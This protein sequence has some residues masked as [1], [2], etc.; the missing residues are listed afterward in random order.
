MTDFLAISL[1]PFWISIY[2]V[3]PTSIFLLWLDRVLT[4]FYLHLDHK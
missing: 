1:A 2:Y 4:K 3:N